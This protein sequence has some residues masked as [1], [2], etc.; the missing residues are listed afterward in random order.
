MDSRFVVK[1]WDDVHMCLGTIDW[2]KSKQ[3][4]PQKLVKLRAKLDAL[5]T[6]LAGL[7]N[8]R[9]IFGKADYKD[10]QDAIKQTEGLIAGWQS[11]LDYQPPK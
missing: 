6:K 2:L 9:G 5:R 11:A 1:W 10:T 7:E 3:M 4:A 8:K